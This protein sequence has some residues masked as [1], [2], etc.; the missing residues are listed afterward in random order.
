MNMHRDLGRAALAAGLAVAVLGSAGN[1]SAQDVDGR[2]LPFLGCWAP[3][4]EGTGVDLV[5]L[6]PAAQQGGVRVAV[7][8]DGEGV[9]SHDIP[10]LFTPF[11]RLGQQNRSKVDGTGLG[12]ALSK[13]L[14]ESMGG[15]IGYDA[16]DKGA[17]FWFTLPVKARP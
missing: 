15:V 16:P 4:A 3:S 14:V 17:R 9:A 5:C 11:D 12:L 10:R 7:E 8:D 13:R 6:R 2:W 1:A